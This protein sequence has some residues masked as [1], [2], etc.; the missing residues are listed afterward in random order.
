MPVHSADGIA[1]GFDSRGEKRLKQLDAAG[2]DVRREHLQKHRERD[3]RFVELAA[4]FQ[5]LRGVIGEWVVAAVVI[6]D[7]R[8]VGP[9]GLRAAAFVNPGV[10]VW[11]DGLRSELPAD[12]VVF[13]GQNHLQS[14]ACGGK[15]A[16][17]AANAAPDDDHIGFQFAV[18]R[19]RNIA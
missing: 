4:E 19:V 2:G 1:V 16:R 18:R 13:L 12:P 7:L 10:L 14:V 9:V 5:L 15:S 8:P 17:N 3:F 6:A 11:R